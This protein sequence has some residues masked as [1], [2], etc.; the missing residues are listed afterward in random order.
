MLKSFWLTWLSLPMC[1]QALALTWVIELMILSKYHWRGWMCQVGW[2]N[3]EL[4]VLGDGQ[5][6]LAQQKGVFF[7]SNNPCW[8]TELYP[9]QRCSRLSGK[10]CSGSEYLQQPVSTF[11]LFLSLHI[12]Y[13]VFLSCSHLI[14]ASRLYYTLNWVVRRSL[15]SYSLGEFV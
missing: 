6:E 12:S 11:S 15:F 9:G 10:T 4:S 1:P 8:T 2:W 14:M 7:G 5:L 13:F 3:G